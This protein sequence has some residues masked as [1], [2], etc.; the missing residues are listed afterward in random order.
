MMA[1][2]KPESD[3]PGYAQFLFPTGWPHFV[4]AV[5][6]MMPALVL[7]WVP[8]S[9]FLL[10]GYD[11]GVSTSVILAGLVLL[12]ITLSHPTFMLTR[13]KRWAR[14]F[15]R[16]YNLF[17]IALLVIGGLAHLFTG[18]T[19]KFYAISIGLIFALIAFKLYR[20]RGFTQFCDHYCI[21]WDAHRERLKSG[22]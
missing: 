2:M 14:P 21:L 5:M 6:S 9:D 3:T 7:S 10:S 8:L 17:C 22:R 12:S 18:N 15:L 1:R 16:W 13:G 11:V 19:S 20:S 4:G